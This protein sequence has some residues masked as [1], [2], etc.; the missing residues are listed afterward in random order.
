MKKLLLMGLLFLTLPAAAEVFVWKDKEYGFTFSY[1]DDWTL[2]TADSATTR[3]RI[4]APLAKDSSATCR[5]KAEKDGRLKIYPKHMM[6][7]AVVEKLDRNFWEQE[8][9]QYYKAVVT[10]YKGPVNMGGQGEATAVKVYFRQNF[11]EGMQDMFGT[12]IGSIYGDMRYIV[13]CSSKVSEY[14]KYAPLFA[15]IMA[16][17]RLDEKYAPWAQGYYRD[18]LSDETVIVPS[19]VR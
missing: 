1:P 5:V 15:S 14:P 12:M 3:I 4:A 2:Q 10:D 18:F 13:G 6:M 16:S 8:A 11:G 7:S 9:N 19:S 17:V